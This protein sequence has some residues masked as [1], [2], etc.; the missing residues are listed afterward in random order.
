MRALEKNGPFI[1]AIAVY[2]DFSSYGSGV[3]VKTAGAKF[4]GYHAVTIVGYGTEDD[5]PYWRV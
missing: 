3:Y 4:Q 1:V 2:S 5:I